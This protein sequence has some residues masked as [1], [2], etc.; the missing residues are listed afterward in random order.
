MASAAVRIGPMLRS[1]YRLL[2]IL[3][4]LL[5]LKRGPGSFARRQARKAAVRGAARAVRRLGR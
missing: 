5:A 4:D 3:T 2:S 1:L